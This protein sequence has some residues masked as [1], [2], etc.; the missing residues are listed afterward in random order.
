MKP[1]KQV[2]EVSVFENKFGT[3]FNDDVVSPSGSKGQYLRWRW[4]NK[5]VVIIPELN[6]YVGLFWMYRYPIQQFS[7]E[8]PR[9]GIDES[10]S[11]E[12]AAR[13]E[14]A[15]EANLM[16][17]NITILGSLYPDTGLIESETVVVLAHI[18]EGAKPHKA[19][20]EVME[21]IDQKAEWIH[22]DYIDSELVSGRIKCGV[23]IAALAL[24][25]ANKLIT[26]G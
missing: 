1:I 20:I 11:I 12:V 18:L 22:H 13:R 24:L 26:E 14:L 4:S 2:K 25:S 16:A 23:T 7:L 5:G 3:L 15:E 21:S 9:G 8:F 19:H 6:S 10:E 17:N